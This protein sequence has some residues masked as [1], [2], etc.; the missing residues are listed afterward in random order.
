MRATLLLLAGW[1]VLAV[2][3]GGAAS[4]WAMVETPAVE[5]WQPVT[6]EIG[7]SEVITWSAYLPFV[8]R[9]AYECQPI[10]GEEYGTL[11]VTGPPTDRPAAEHA[12]L[13]L[14]LRGYEVTDAFLGLVHYNG[15][16]DPKAPQLSGLFVPQRLP[17]FTTVYKVY[18]WNWGCN[19]R[20]DLLTKYDVTLAGM[21][22]TPGEKIHVPSSGYAISPDYEV[23]VLY[24]TEERITLKYTPHDNVV[25]G[26][27]IHVE[28]VCVEPSLLAL[29]QQW[30]GAGRAELPAL[31][32]GQ[33]FGRARG[34]EIGVAI[35]DAG[36]FMDPRSDKD[37]WQGW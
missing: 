24:A 25:N 7:A 22:V 37:W 21:G 3:G 15:D 10:P 36:T 35:R 14:A 33:A 18:D 16:F 17:A 34:W 29:Y 11:D 8:A 26:Y 23:L 1:G 19:C 12:D 2:L 13:N 32:A 20:G 5:S 27:T 9:T 4:G 31:E 28:N 30:N 6:A